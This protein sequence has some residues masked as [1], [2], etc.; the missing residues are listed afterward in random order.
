MLTF[1]QPKLALA[2]RRDGHG[3]RAVRRGIERAHD[4]VV[5]VRAQHELVRDADAQPALDHGDHGVIVRRL[6]ADVGVHVRGVEHAQRV[7]VRAVDQAHDRFRAEGRDGH[8]LAR[9]QRVARRQHGQ[10][11][12]AA[13]GHDLARQLARQRDEAHVH[14]AAA[15]VGVHLGVRPVEQAEARLRMLHLKLLDHRRQPVDRHALERRNADRAAGALAHLLDAAAQVRI[16]RAHLLHGRQQRLARRGQVHAAAVAYQQ[17][18]AAVALEPRQQLRQR[19]LGHAQRLCRGR[20]ARALH[21][22]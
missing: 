1:S 22:F 5:V 19:R 11:P 9:R 14:R 7:A 3:D 12:V 18:K 15:H 2:L 13:H 21:R 16:R 20:H 6:K 8:G 17:G 4:D 10:Q